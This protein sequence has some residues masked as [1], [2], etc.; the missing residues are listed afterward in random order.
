MHS[1]V[2]RMQHQEPEDDDTGLCT[3]AAASPPLSAAAAATA[4]ASARTGTAM[5][6]TAMPRR[7]LR[8]APVHA[9][10][11]FVWLWYLSSSS[12]RGCRGPAACGHMDTFN[13]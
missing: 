7:V 9:L 12:S 5:L 2:E 1:T 3:C 11:C 10:Q 13:A 4:D 8:S 6:V